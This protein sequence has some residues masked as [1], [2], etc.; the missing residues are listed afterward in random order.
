MEEITKSMKHSYNKFFNV[1]ASI[2]VFIAVGN[3]IIDLL[4][5]FAFH[6]FIWVK[7]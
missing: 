3:D 5:I 2:I 7:V 6:I 1:D 4:S